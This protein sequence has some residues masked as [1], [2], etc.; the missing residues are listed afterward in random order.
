MCLFHLPNTVGTVEKYETPKM[1][2]RR[3]SPSLRR[4]NGIKEAVATRHVEKNKINGDKAVAP[5]SRRKWRQ[6]NKEN[7]P[8]WT[9]FSY[10]VA[11]VGWEATQHEK[12]A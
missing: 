3:Q 2:T 9:R 11:G 6:S 8:N 4:K 12:R 7:V 10:W 1:A 5:S